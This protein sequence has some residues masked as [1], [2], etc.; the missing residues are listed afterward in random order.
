MTFKKYKE[1]DDFN[2]P[3][4]GLDTVQFIIDVLLFLSGKIASKKY[5]VVIFKTLSFLFALFL[6]AVVILLW[7]L[8]FYHHTFS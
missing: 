4:L 8:L 1:D 2:D 7:V 5:H 6:L 3:T